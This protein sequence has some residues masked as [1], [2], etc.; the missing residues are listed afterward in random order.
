MAARMVAMSCLRQCRQPD[1]RTATDYNKARQARD[2]RK[3]FSE[4]V[5]AR[6]CLRIKRY[7]S[8]E[9]KITQIIGAVVYVAFPRDS[10]PNV[11]KLCS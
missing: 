3:S 11:Y 1:R 10:I 8:A 4:I 2:H 6:R 5:V 9:G 7:G